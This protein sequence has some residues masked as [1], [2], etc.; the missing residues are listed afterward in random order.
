MVQHTSLTRKYLLIYNIKILCSH[1]AAIF[2]I[3]LV[4]FVHHTHPKSEASSFY[5]LARSHSEPLVVV[6][7]PEVELIQNRG[8]DLFAGMTKL[9]ISTF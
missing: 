3:C 9:S 1:L 6:F 4:K 2:M 5:H 8:R 7:S